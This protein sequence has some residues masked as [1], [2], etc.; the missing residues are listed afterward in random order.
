MG[1]KEPLFLEP[2]AQVP[3]PVEIDPG[4]Q[5]RVARL[6]FQTIDTIIG[7][8][9]LRFQPH[10]LFENCSTDAARR[11]ITDAWRASTQPDNSRAA[12]RADSNASGPAATSASTF[13]RCPTRSTNSPISTPTTMTNSCHRVAGA[14]E[15]GRRSEGNAHPGRLGSDEREGVPV[16]LGFGNCELDVARVV[17]RRDGAEIPVEPQ[18]FDLLC[19]LIDRRGQVVRKEDLLDQVW[20]D[21]FVSESALTTRIKS[22]RRAVGD[23]GAR[24]VV[25]RTVHGKGYEFVAE[26]RLI[27]AQ[28][29]PARRFDVDRPSTGG[30]L[31]AALQ[32]LIGRGDLLARLVDDQAAHRL[33]TLVGT[34]GVGKT[35]VGFEL[36]RLVANTYADGVFVVE[37][38]TIVDADAAFGAFATALDVNTRQQIS[39]EDAIVDMLRPR[40]ALLMLDNC[41]HL[42]ESIAVLVDRILRAAPNVSVVATSREPLAVTGEHVRVVEPLATAGLERVPTDELAAVPAVALFLERAQAAD[43]SFEI[44]ATTAPAIVEICC[45]LDG[46]PLAIELAASRAS[47]IDVNEIA[48]RLDE[49]FRLLKGVRRGADPRHGT[50]HDAISWSYELLDGDEQRLFASLAVFAGQ[51]DLGAAEAVC[52]G[53]D[54]LDLLTRLTQRSMLA[55][56]RPPTGGTRYEMLET[57]REYGRGRLDDQR[58][59]ELFGAHAAQF[60]ALASSVELDLQTAQEHDAVAR[61]DASFAD[62]RAA[63]RFALEIEDVDTAYRLIGSIREYAMRTLRYEV[64]NWADAALR[65]PSGADHPLRPIIVGVSAYGAWVRGEFGIAMSLAE[66]ARADEQARGVSPTGLVERVK[67][68]VMYATGEIEFGLIEGARSIELAEASLNDSRIA[69]AY[70]MA[71]VASSSLGRYDE[72]QRLIARAREAGRRTGSPTDLASASVAE[73]FASCDDDAA[74]DAFATADRLSRSAGNRWMSAFARTEASGLLVH[75]GLLREGCEGLAQM[76]DT[77]YRAGEWAQQWH[78]MSRCVI[79]LD[80]IGEHELAAVVLGAIEAHTTMGGPPVMTTLRDLAFETRASVATHLGQARAEEL[81]AAGASLP[82]ATVVDRTRNALLGRSVGG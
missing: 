41:E 17:L 13:D 25:I 20:G 22:A 43:P 55:V 29:A 63:Q 57:L 19:C 35:S 73:G 69:H 18:V 70:Y 10:P 38:V 66:S 65:L 54:V 45:R 12:I 50:L 16:I 7:L 44:N 64:F 27:D 3:H 47:A 2:A 28:S 46:I 82:V 71:S 32:P 77:W 26:V 36:A 33:V 68:N 80:R 31:P 78:T 48:H 40:H 51:F 5:P 76:V 61:A 58:S 79:A 52:R 39:I 60:A 75:R 24:Q 8:G 15:R 72:A 21:R 6:A 23:D 42:V 53:E 62:L 14:G 9:P 11:A 30:A 56:R 49:R 37:L 67:A 34:A 59:V 74:L 81:W 4:G 1:G